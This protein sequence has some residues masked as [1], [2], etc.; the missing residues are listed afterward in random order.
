MKRCRAL[1]YSTL[2]LNLRSKVL[3]LGLALPH[4]ALVDEHAGEL[5][6]DRLLQQERE[7]DES[8]PPESASSSILPTCSRTNATASSMNAE[9]VQSGSHPQ[10]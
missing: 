2:M 5:I 7:V 4:E 8:T 1:M 10:M 3:E 6:T 9:V